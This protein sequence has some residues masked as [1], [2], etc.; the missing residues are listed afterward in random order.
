MRTDR[1]ENRKGPR[2]FERGER[3]SSGGE[4]SFGGRFQSGPREWSSS[5]PREMHKATCAECKSSCEVPFKPIEGK[6]V[7]C[8]DCYRKRKERY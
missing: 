7:F 3:R 1:R 8:R 4:R 5:E 2:T 6:P